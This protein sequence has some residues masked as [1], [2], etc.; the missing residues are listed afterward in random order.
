MSNNKSSSSWGLE[1]DWLLR[2]LQK[3]EVTAEDIRGIVSSPLNMSRGNYLPID[4]YLHLFAWAA[5]RLKSPHIGMEIA[6]Q[7]STEDLGIYGY[8]TQ[9]ERD[10]NNRWTVFHDS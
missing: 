3:R 4:E 9:N 5:K 6:A 10:H 2:Y 1:V 7:T 8:L